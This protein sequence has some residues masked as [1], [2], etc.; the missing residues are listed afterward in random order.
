TVT[1]VQTCALPILCGRLEAEEDV[2]IQR[3]QPGAVGWFDLDSL[4][5]MQAARRSRLITAKTG[6]DMGIPFNELNRIF[7]LGFNALPW[8]DD[9]YLPAQLQKVSSPG[10]AGVSPASSGVLPNSFG[11]A[12]AGGVPSQ[13]NGHAGV[14]DPVLRP[15]LD[16]E[17]ILKLTK[18][19]HH[20]ILDKSSKADLLQALQRALEFIQKSQLPCP[21]LRE[22]LTFLTKVQE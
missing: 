5:I 12:S 20:L 13:P 4:P 9:G 1:G 15:A 14:T 3:L 18:D 22:E 19:F 2:V 16:A 6:F 17:L 10:T 11:P 21:R 8:G 7:D